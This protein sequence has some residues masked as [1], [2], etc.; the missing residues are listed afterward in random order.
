[1]TAAADTRTRA[2]RAADDRDSVRSNLEQLGTLGAVKWAAKELPSVP[3]E[4]VHKRR[5]LILTIQE[6]ARQADDEIRRARRLARC[7]VQGLKQRKQWR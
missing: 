2:Q 7:H 6:G 3:P 5:M 4:N 1:M